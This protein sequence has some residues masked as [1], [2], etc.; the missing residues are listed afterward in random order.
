MVFIVILKPLRDELENCLGIWQW[1]DVNIIPFEGFDKSF[2]HPVA[3]RAFDR[4]EAGFE[5]ELPGKDDRFLGYISRSIIGQHL[6]C[7]WSAQRPKSFLNRFEHHIADVRAADAA[8]D[9]TTPGHDLAIMSID[10]KGDPDDVPVPAGELEAVT[11]PTQIRS[12]NDDLAVMGQI[13]PFR[14]APCQKHLVYLHDP[15]DTLVIDQFV[16]VFA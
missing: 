12:H 4:C 14:I 16:A 15:V 6:D 1:V 11:A 13:R 9:D 3:L 10:D 7:L 5:I 8:I 2:R